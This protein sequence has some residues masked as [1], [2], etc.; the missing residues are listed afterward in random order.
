MASGLRSSLLVVMVGLA[1]CG[2]E[3]AD[4]T[5]PDDP[6]TR[7]FTL[8]IHSGGDGSGTV[9]TTQ[10]TVPA[11]QCTV[12]EGQV[13]PTGCS[14]SYDSGSVVVLEASASEG[15]SFQAWG[16]AASDC[17]TSGVC[18]VILD[19][20]QTVLVTF[21]QIPQPE[22]TSFNWR[23]DP[24]F[25]SEGAVIWVVDV[26]N[27]TALTLELVRVDF[28]TRD[29]A[30]TILSSDFT[31][32]GPI[33]PGET[34][35]SESF[36]DYTGQETT[37]DFLVTDVQVATGGNP[38]EGLAITSSNWRAD[39]DFGFEGAIIWTVEVTNTTDRTA[40]NVRVDFN[41]YDA[42]GTILTSTFTFLPAIPP[43]ES[44][45]SE[46]FADYF[47]TEASVEFEVGDAGSLATVMARVAGR[48]VAARNTALQRLASFVR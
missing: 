16:E 6:Q 24:E 13:G 2:D 39:P 1:A 23:V 12:A 30:G 32:V 28:S 8:V 37:A 27:P 43:T 5:G 17:G 10:G 38:L 7:Q 4:S 42:N 31:F 21:A 20:P 45:T 46:S 11:L 22:I 15:S 35:A 18:T 41:T 33:P 3:G 29:A 47:G 40:D 34:R 26:L 44:R 19:A 25:G 14:A 9:T 36:S 48:R